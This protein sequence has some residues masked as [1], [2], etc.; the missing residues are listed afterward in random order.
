MAEFILTQEEADA[1]LAMEKHRVNVRV[2]TLPMSGQNEV[3]DLV[4]FD[5]RERFLFDL[6]RKRS[7]LKN[8]RF[9]TRA[10]S[11]VTLV[12]LDLEG[13]YHTSLEGERVPTPHLHLYNE[14]HGS[15]FALPV[16]SE[17]FSNLEDMWTTLNDFMRYCNI[18]RPPVFRHPSFQPGLF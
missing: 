12:R 14:V 7:R 1:L 4:S 13:P 9:Q 16:P 5:G 11:S 6:Y 8:I 17:A 10:R 3:I 15:R 18:T 2:H